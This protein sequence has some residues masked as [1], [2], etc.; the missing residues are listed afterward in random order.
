MVVMAK[1]QQK[2][3]KAR[4]QVQTL[5]SPKEISRVETLGSTLTVKDKELLAMVRNDQGR[6][7]EPPNKI[8]GTFGIKDPDGR[9]HLVG[10]RVTGT[11]RDHR[12]GAVEDVVPLS[13]YHKDLFACMFKGW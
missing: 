5:R 10:W 11:R 9:E 8:V 3:K 13:D 1:Q 6:M 7:Y 4:T 2:K 12:H